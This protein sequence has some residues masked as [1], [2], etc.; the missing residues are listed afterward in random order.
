MAQAGFIPAHPPRR[1]RVGPF[2][3]AFVGEHARNAVTGWSNAAFEDWY[4][5]RKL[6]RLTVHIP[7]H[8]DAIE[9]VLLTNAANYAKPRIVKRLIA[10]L[11]GNGLLSADGESWRQQRRIVAPS[12]APGAV[13]KLTGLMA[14][15]AREGTAKW[16]QSGTVD[17][18]ETAT[19][20]TMAIIARALFSGDPRLMTEDAGRHITAALEAAGSARL[21]AI[22]GMPGLR[23]TPT[24]WA[25]ARGQRFLRETLTDIVRERGPEG[26]DD[27]LGGM[28]RDLHE[29]FPRSEAL[30][31]AIDNAATFYLAGH[32]TTAN[33]L[34]WSIYCLAGDQQAQD[35]ACSEVRAA[36]DGDPQTLPDRLP[37]LR[38]ILDEA[39]RLYPPAPRF[40][41][42]ALSDD[43][44]DGHPVRAGEIVS[45][46][47]WVLHRHRKL[48]DDADRFDPDRFA[49]DR[50]RERHRFQYI[51]F[52]GGPRTCVGA[53]FATVEALVILAHWIAARRF[54]LPPGREVELSAAVTLRPR[55]GLWV[56]VA[57]RD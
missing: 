37:F 26:G 17:I 1:D 29:R 54:A 55:G 50:E 15:A 21:A 28:I 42:E 39:L 7:R 38:Q 10:P 11:I 27:F 36:I 46:W 45:I 47:P 12:F 33:A 57:P 52:G 32:E 16:P 30:K 40:D 49:P 35:R 31:L 51:P 22:L 25:G 34:T 53:R 8:P 9:R 44:L 56:E 13:A 6:L 41:R 43:M 14:Q 18:A 48:W 20:A 2:W 4:T 3:S 19:D 5:K 23:L 24:A